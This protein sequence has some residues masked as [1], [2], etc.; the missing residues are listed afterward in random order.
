MYK[1]KIKKILANNIIDEEIFDKKLYNTLLLGIFEAIC[2]DIKKSNTYI[3]EKEKYRKNPDK[4]SATRLLVKRYVNCMLDDD[5]YEI[6]E[7]YFRAYFQKDGRRK[8]FDDQFRLKLLNEQNYKCN[9]CGKQ[10]DNSSSHLDHIVPWDYVGDCLED[11]YQMLCGT[12]NTRKGASTYYEIAMT[13]LNR[14]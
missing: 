5:D 13:L 2:K 12:C 7:K 1:D 14:R 9:I 8:N 6:L 3:E 10:I 11:N 4:T